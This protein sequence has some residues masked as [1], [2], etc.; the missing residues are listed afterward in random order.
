MNSAGRSALQE[1]LTALAR[2]ERAA[3]D[4]LFRRL[5]PLLRG[6][7]RRFLPAEEADDAAQEA[8]LRIFRRAS[9]F[10]P[11]RDA[12][13]WAMGVA[14]WQVR[15]HRTKA[16]RRREDIAQPL[17]ERED[18]SASPEEQAAAGELAAALERALAEL[19]PDDAATLLAYARGERPDLPGATFRK[20]VERALNRLRA[21][22]RIRHDSL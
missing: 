13:A 17:P 21:R 16:R 7:A 5:W 6:F 14:A 3:F 11:A 9:E 20:R 15:T 2:G 19:R 4:P 18:P 10:D 22:W 8:L 12:L 1:E